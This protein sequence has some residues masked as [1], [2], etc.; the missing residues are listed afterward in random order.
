MQLSSNEFAQAGRVEPTASNYDTEQLLSRLCVDVES[1]S[2]GEVFPGTAP[3][4]PAVNQF[5]V[6]YI[7]KGDGLLEWHSGKVALAEGMIAVIPSGLQ[8]KLRNRV[9]CAAANDA[10]AEQRAPNPTAAADTSD[11]LIVASAIVGASAGHGLGYFESLTRPLVEESDDAVLRVIFGAILT[12]IETPGIGS[13]CIVESLMKQILIVLLRRTLLCQHGITPLYQT[14][15]N[16]RL[17]KVINAIQGSHAERLSLPGLASIVGMT[18]F[19][20]TREF[21]R[22]FGESL[23]DYIQGVRLEQATSLLTQ[24]DLPIKSIAAS[25]GYASRSHFSRAFRKH[26][27]EDPTSF[28]KTAANNGVMSPSVQAHA[29]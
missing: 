24:T 18:S 6:L 20:L 14:I 9:V 15:A 7:V 10:A 17:A 25:V 4:F 21:E 29:S 13:K 26:S 2:V 28:R 8:T 22:V 23:L 12:E 3:R 19:G 16:P 27:G 11:N 5:V 1:F